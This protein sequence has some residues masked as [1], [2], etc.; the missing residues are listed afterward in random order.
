MFLYAKLV[1]ENLLRQRTQ[2]DLMRE[3]EPNTFPE[4]LEDAYVDTRS[5]ALTREL[6]SY[7]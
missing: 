4:G 6:T 5:T 1:M 3:L 2:E 7:Y